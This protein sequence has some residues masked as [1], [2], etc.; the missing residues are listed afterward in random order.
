[1]KDEE[2][3]QKAHVR[4]QGAKQVLHHCPQQHCQARAQGGCEEE[5]LDQLA[6]LGSSR[7]SRCHLCT[8]RHAVSLLARILLLVLLLVLVASYHPF[9]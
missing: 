4:R 8:R 3:L 2:L 9:L 7:A 6:A 1:M 5:K